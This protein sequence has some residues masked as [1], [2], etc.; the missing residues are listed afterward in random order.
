MR[1]QDGIREMIKCHP[2]PV[3]KDNGKTGSLEAQRRGI[4]L[5]SFLGHGA[6]ATGADNTI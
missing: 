2:Q 5:R 6:Y 1:S 4:F 3:E